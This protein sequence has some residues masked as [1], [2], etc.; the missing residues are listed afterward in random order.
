[1]E[2]T[3]TTT[4]DPTSVADGRIGDGR[5][6]EPAPSWRRHARPARWLAG[7]A[8]VL[9]LGWL[10][11][12]VPLSG[13]T[14]GLPMAAAI[15]GWT[16]CLEDGLWPCT[17]VGYPEGADLST[18]MPLV[19][20]VYLLTRTGLEV[21]VALNLLALGA[22]AAGFAAMWWV[23]AAITR[24]AGA[25]IVGAGVYSLS[26]LLVTHVDKTGLWLGFVLLPV[27]VALTYAAVREARP[28]AR[29]RTLGALGA[30]VLVFLSALLIVYLDPYAWTIA[31]VLCV[32]MCVVA[33]AI[34][35]RRR[36][37]PN[38]AVAVVTTAAVLVP[39]VVFRLREP[40]AEAAAGFSPSVYRAFGA[41]L[42]TAILPTRDSL[43]WDVLRSPANPW[44]PSRFR[45]DGTQLL[46][47]YL[48]V[49]VVV[50]A[51][52]GAVHLLRRSE[53]DRPIVAA[54]VVGG[55][56][57]LALGLGP[58]LKLLDTWPNGVTEAATV[59]GSIYRMPAVEATAPLP[60][61]GLYGVQPFEGMRAV[62]RWHAGARLV[63]AVLAAAAVV[64]VAGRRWS[65]RR[66]LGLALAVVLAAILTLDTMSHVLVEAR[67]DARNHHEAYRALEADIGA[68][69]GRGQ[70]A[71]S[72]RVLFL[73]A[74]NDYLIMAIAPRLQVFAY[75]VSFDKEVN[76]VRRYQPRSV[77]EAI[78]AYNGSTLTRAHVCAVFRED[79]ADAVVFTNFDMRRDSGDWPPPD[80][81][82]GSLREQNRAPGLFDDPA[83]EVVEQELTTIVRPAEGSLAGCS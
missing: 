25:G 26:P 8:C 20:G 51:I 41:D 1:M 67:A 56:A 5:H 74:S 59:R 69:L 81:R 48:G 29:R 28:P 49:T 63:L 77:L 60:W 83:F 39:G 24:H 47:A 37:W 54:L 71:P 45:G 22:L 21:E 64:T 23:T 11:G 33:G 75:N 31:G 53:R 27:P 4:A 44:D 40:A 19:G 73:P 55:L 6:D 32:P 3:T 34:A 10:Y 17:Y 57:C 46:G 42:G 72:E 12:V 62:Y 82:V 58:S 16:D 80:S 30:G 36:G 14:F 38:L 2:T 50:A 9:A 13:R 79:A 35:A 78:R 43:L 65:A 15:Q 18:S 7:A 68:E 76:R 70:L 52:V 61:S 66:S